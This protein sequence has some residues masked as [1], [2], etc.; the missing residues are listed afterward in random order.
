MKKVILIITV[1]LSFILNQFKND[2]PAEVSDPIKVKKIKLRSTQT[3][4]VDLSERGL[5][6]NTAGRSLSSGIGETEGFLDVNSSGAAT[7]QIPI[8]VAPGI[9]GVAP[10]LDLFYNSQSGNGIAGYGWHVNGI[11]MITRAPSSQYQDGII[12]E[13]DFQNDKFSLDGMRLTKTIGGGN[14]YKTVEFSNLRIRGI[15]TSPYGSNYGPNYFIVYYPDGSRAYYGQTGDSKSKMA[16]ALNLWKNPQGVTIYY[17]YYSGIN[18][19]FIKNIEYGALEGSN[20]LNKIEF[21]YGD[22]PRV[23]NSWNGDS[24]SKMSHL[25]EE[26]KVFGNNNPIRT[27]ILTHDE[28]SLDYSR[29]KELTEYSG[30]N[31]SNHTP[32]EFYYSD[33]ADGINRNDITTDLNLSGINLEDSEVIT[34]DYSGNGEM[35]F[36]AYQKNDKTKF[37]MFEDIIDAQTNE[38]T[39]VTTGL[40]KELFP[41]N[42]KNNTNKV[43][44]QQAIGMIKNSAPDNITFSIHANAPSNPFSL[45]YSKVWDTPTYT[46]TNSIGQTVT[47]RRP[48][49]YISGDFDGDGLSDLISISKEYYVPVQCNPPNTPV[50]CFVE[51]SPKEAYFINLREEITSN[52]VTEV[53]D[54]LHSYN[55][56]DYSIKVADFNGDGKS[57]IWLVGDSHLSIYGLSYNTV[58]N[59][60]QL[61]ELYE[62]SLSFYDP[63]APMLLGD[64]N[65]DGKTDFIYPTNFDSNQFRLAYSTGTIFDLYQRILPFTYKESVESEGIVILNNLI[66]ADIDGDGRTD[67]IEYIAGTDEDNINY[68]SQTVK[69]YINQL[70][71]PSFN[72]TFIVGDMNTKDGQISPY[73]IPV[74]LTSE[75][76]NKSLEFASISD[77]WITSWNFNSDH[78]EDVLLRKVENNGVTNNIEYSSLDPDSYNEDNMQ[79]YHPVLEEVYPNVDVQIS[80]S[81]KVVSKLDRVVPNTQTLKKLFAYQGATHNLEGLG[82][83]GF[84]GMA[85]SNWHTGQI[86]RIFNVTKYSSTLRGAPT[87]SYQLPYDFNFNSINSDYI[88]KTYYTYDSSISSDKIFKKWLSSSYSVNQLEGNTFKSVVYQYDNYN[89]PTRITTHRNGN[90]RRTVD[91]EYENNTSTFNYYIGR[92]KKQ[93][94]ETQI[95]ADAFT[96]EKEYTYNGYLVS[97]IKSKGNN[98]PVNNQDFT[99]DTYGNLIKEINTPWGESSREVLFEYDTTGRFITKSIDVEGLETDY[100]YS[101]STGLITQEVNPFNQQTQYE[102]DEWNRVE[103]VIDYLDNTTRT[104]YSESNFEYTVTQQGEDESERI[105][106]YDALG[107][108]IKVS[109]NNALGQM[110]NVSY[111]YDK[112]DRV[113]KESEPYIGTS[114]TQWN[115]KEYDF[116]GRLVYE[117]YYNGRT[118]TY[119]HNGLTTTVDDGVKITTTE[120]NAV[121]KMKSLTDPGGT[122]NYQYY[123]NGALK[124]TEYEGIVVS[125]EQDGWGRKTKTIDPSAGTFTYEYNGFGEMTLET[126]PKGSTSITYSDVGKVTQKAITGD[127]TDITWNYT[128]DPDSKFLT[129]LNQLSTGNN[130]TYSYTYD[131]YERLKSV[132]EIN[133][134]AQFKKE[135]TFDQYGRVAT[136]EYYGKLFA[137]NGESS[138][139]IKNVYNKGELKAIK[140]HVTN[141]TLWEIDGL[142]ARGQLTRASMGTDLVEQNQYD[143]YGYL[144][145]NSVKKGQGSFQQT[146]M[147]IETDFDIQRGNLLSRDNSM[148]SISETFSYDSLE[149]LTTITSNA[150]SSFVTY[151]NLGRIQENSTVGAYN[152]DNNSFKVDDIELNLPGD[153][154]YQQNELQQI[155]Y[156]AFKKPFDITEQDSERI[157]FEYNAFM[158]RAHMYYGNEEEDIQLRSRRKHYSHD[159]S[160]EISH[161]LETGAVEFVTYLGG[162]AYNAPIIWKSD[163]AGIPQEDY[164]YLHRDYLGSILM[165]SDGDGNIQEKRHFGAWGETVKVEDGQGN[166]LEELTFLDRGYTGHE[167]LQGV[168]LI[169]MNG[170][171][172]DPKLKR[173]LAPDNFIQDPFNTQN[174]NRYGYVLNNPLKY[175]DPTGETGVETIATIIAIVKWVAVAGVAGGIIKNIVDQSNATTSINNAPQSSPIASES[176]TSSQRI[177]N[178]YTNLSREL[179]MTYSLDELNV[180]TNPSGMAISQEFN[181]IVGSDASIRDS[182]NE[183]NDGFNIT[184]ADVL[185]TALDFVP[186]AGGVKDIYQGIRDGNGWLV[187]LGVGSIVLDVVTLGSSS[188][189]KGAVKTAA[190]QGIRAAGKQVAKESVQNLSKSITSQYTDGIASNSVKRVSNLPSLGISRFDAIDLAKASGDDLFNYA[191]IFEN[192]YKAGKISAMTRDQAARFAR[193]L[194]KRGVKVRIDNPHRAPNPWQMKHLN[195]GDKG[196]IH[197]PILD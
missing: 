63:N 72:T 13:I 87:L 165:I 185:D 10:Q 44:S 97:N 188:L 58:S 46:F 168:H 82:F 148:F 41:M 1:L 119:T 34:L 50:P 80:P 88:V 90:I 114:P 104:V 177:S 176:Q 163:Q 5:N 57:D 56:E 102:Y 106:T 48:F 40:F 73:P 158:G 107:R 179:N 143:S 12:D 93:T 193:L 20:Q 113:W 160:T 174:Y 164:Y 144:Q 4:T 19:L 43:L 192:K 51:V 117:S 42:W 141:N 100:G 79:I 173:F 122:I 125:M 127:N 135:Y 91:L 33:T 7:Y 38:A 137:T 21:I 66:P 74:F 77:S 146:L 111:E 18:S 64:Y 2:R 133:G 94:E 110:V 3:S 120:L 161:N 151:D 55:D 45:Q 149:R 23:E 145:S 152:Y 124:Q 140:D 85:S 99:Y 71:P 49:K 194:R 169:H 11:S 159:G 150:G 103:K 195:V 197:I 162:D 105:A 142:T 54:L 25:L 170:R 47:E 14:E 166:E 84:K 101:N 186:I 181:P 147:N 130:A 29:L 172:Y 136:E 8:T 22:R 9:N 31:S 53:G 154:Y 36:L 196:Q 108:L 139:K 16:Y 155:T 138:K 75:Q 37:W 175:I 81:T 156:N 129:T 32:I 98:T 131:N 61:I 123:G 15:G 112:F 126:T 39:E 60:N 6:L 28:T 187:A 65:G 17:S 191:K 70:N 115:T 157:G 30:D 182:L 190:K 153:L 83:L 184:G 86:D 128:Y 69:T 27:Y 92:L 132:E 95:D 24:F 116:Y 118:I 52:F 76:E 121:G 109:E 96:A 178:G 67:I 167:H 78:R 26:I 89:N 134:R 171:L 189:I 183:D 62:S 35:D 68:G 180:V 59:E